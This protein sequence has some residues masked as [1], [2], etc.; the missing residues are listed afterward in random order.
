MSSN[1]PLGSVSDLQPPIATKGPLSSSAA[2]ASAIIFRLSILD[3]WYSSGG[4]AGFALAS[5]SFL[6]LFAADWAASL[7]FIISL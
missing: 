6:S 4:K 5:S 2:L 3:G 1:T 7:S